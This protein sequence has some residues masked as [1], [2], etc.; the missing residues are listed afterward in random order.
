MPTTIYRFIALSLAQF[1]ISPAYS[2]TDPALQAITE[3]S[4]VNGQALACQEFKAATRAKNLM[5][6]HSPKTARYGS[7][8]DEGTH[9]AFVAQT[10]GPAPC[11]DANTLSSQLEALALKLQASLPAAVPATGVQ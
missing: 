5:L 4:Q 3:L 8:F 2:Q 10:R 6:L 11:P 7:A 9:Q 1:L